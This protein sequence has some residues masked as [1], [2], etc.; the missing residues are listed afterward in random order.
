MSDE[1]IAADEAALAVSKDSLDD[2]YEA[3][4]DASLV[5]TTNG[6]VTAVNLTVGE[7]LGSSGIG[8][9]SQT[10]SQSGS[11]ASSGNVGN[12]GAS[13]ANG[14]NGTG[15]TGSTSTPDVEVISTGSYTVDLSV[16]SSEITSV[17]VGQPATVSLAS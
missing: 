3:L 16:D 2:A 17:E 14:Q 9:T 4:A 1:Q 5:A 13:G 8:G 10:G 15:L 11:G 6:T 7:Q 12:G